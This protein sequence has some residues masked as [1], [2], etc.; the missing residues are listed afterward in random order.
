MD[1]KLYLLG[2]G[3]IIRVNGVKVQDDI[4]ESMQL[5]LGGDEVRVESLWV[6]PPATASVV[7]DVK[8]WE[9][10]GT[11]IWDAASWGD[12]TAAEVMTTWLLVTE[13]LR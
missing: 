7:F 6:R 2:E 3:D 13:P 12:T 10:T 5:C 11:T 9:N 4:Y 1:F 8:T